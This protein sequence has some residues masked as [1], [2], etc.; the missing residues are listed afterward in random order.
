MTIHDF[1]VKN[2]KNEDV[3]LADYK[4]KV[5]LVVNTATKCGLTP[6]YEAME[7]LYKK[8][9]DK[10]FEI[11]D[12]PCNQFKEQTPDSDEEITAFC[13]MKYGTTFPRFKKIDVNGESESPLF[14]WLKEQ[15]PKDK[16]SLK[17]KAF[18]LTV[19]GLRT[20][21]GA[22]D[23]VWNFGKFLIGKDGQVV[24]RY[25][26]VSDPQEVSADIEKLLAQ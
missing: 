25:S 7:A 20:T 19:K 6:Q 17:T 16:S 14:T 4:G 26:P 2:N 13:T 24:G 12:F 18:E 8:Y 9:H 3:S 21:K 1:T 5:L 11:L 10:G 23:I 22:S 15:A